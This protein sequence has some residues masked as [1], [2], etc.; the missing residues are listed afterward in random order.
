MDITR[1]VVSS[2]GWLALSSFIL[3]T[4]A[5]AASVCARGAQKMPGQRK[6]S[7][8]SLSAVALDYLVKYGVIGS[9]ADLA[10]LVTF[11]IVTSRSGAVWC[12]NFSDKDARARK[13]LQQAISWVTF[14]LCV[15]FAYASQVTVKGSFDP[16]TLLVLAGNGFACLADSL[17]VVIW[18]RRSH[19]MMAAFMLAFAIYTD[20]WALMAKASIDLGACIYFDP[21]FGE[22][23]RERIKDALRSIFVQRRPKLA[24]VEHR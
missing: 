5:M 13:A 3:L 6:W 24:A 12:F 7:T 19:F 15:G 11:T 9:G 8:I 14:A 17:N 22:D 21:L 4:C 16:L 10:G 23:R 20:C 1:L 18:R 2:G